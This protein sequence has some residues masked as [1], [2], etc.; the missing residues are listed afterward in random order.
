MSGSPLAGCGG[1]IIWHTGRQW[2]GITADKLR[3]GVEGA[4]THSATSPDRTTREPGTTTGP[5]TDDPART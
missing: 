3:I 5:R 1:V 4:P 2:A